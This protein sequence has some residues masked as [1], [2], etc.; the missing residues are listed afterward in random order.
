MSM[1]D[2]QVWV[3]GATG[4]TGRGVAGRL[5]GTGHQVVLVGRDAHRLA[6]L[7]ETL[8]DASVIA[9]SLQDVLE[10]VRQARPAVVLST[11][12]PFGRTADQ[13]MDALPPGTNYAD[14]G[15]ELPGTQAV[16]DRHDRAVTQ[17]S[18]NV[19]GA[20]FGVLATEAAAVYL[21]SDRTRPARMR[22]DAIPSLAT[23]GG[24]IGDALA[25]S[26]LDN[27]PD[28]GRQVKEGRLVR[29]GVAGARLAL[30]TP[31]GDSATTASL[32]TGD[33]LAAW[34]ASDAEAVISAT[35]AIPSE[36][37]IRALFPVLALGIALLS[38][39]SPR[40]RSTGPGF[41]A[42]E[43]APPNLVLGT[44]PRRLGGR[45]VPRS[46]VADGR[47]PGFHRG[48]RGRSRPAPPRRPRPGRLRTSCV[49]RRSPGH[50]PGRRLRRMTPRSLVTGQ[51]ATNARWVFPRL[52][53]RMDVS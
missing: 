8:D 24:F 44:R 42:G 20:G 6:E 3:L 25:G 46:L 48:N 36:P 16:L 23:T 1:A 22:V 13:V 40:N 29:A 35:A 39:T 31:D 47:R 10:R 21:S 2:Q 37:A 14:I 5:D 9:G 26:M 34:R 50:R 32:P 51:P 18:T 28:G 27:A 43:G 7:A 12:G 38:S 33:L 17:G 45:H 41:P 52:D 19:S 30:T 4:R 15:N 11:V 49:V 53:E